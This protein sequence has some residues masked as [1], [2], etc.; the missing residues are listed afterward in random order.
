MLHRQPCAG[1]PACLQ[2]PAIDSVR[3]PSLGYLARVRVAIKPDNPMH[4]LPVHLCSNLAADL[5]CLAKDCYMQGSKCVLF[6]I[7]GAQSGRWSP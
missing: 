6:Y 3:H 2:T 7:A 1:V 5:T 4:P